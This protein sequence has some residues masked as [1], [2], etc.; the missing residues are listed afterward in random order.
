MG[1]LSTD[2]HFPRLSVVLSTTNTWYTP[3][4]AGNVLAMNQSCLCQDYLWNTEHFWKLRTLI[5]VN[6]NL[7]FFAL[8]GTESYGSRESLCTRLDA[9]SNLF[10][11]FLHEISEI[12]S[13]WWLWKETMSCISSLCNLECTTIKRY[14]LFNDASRSSPNL[15]YKRRSIFRKT[16]LRREVV[17]TS[18]LWTGRPWI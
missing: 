6:F 2:A 9:F 18:G 8:L 16:K 7:S 11:A 4:F 10:S 1:N 17:A 12:S 13:S 5:F 3:A 15:I 14:S